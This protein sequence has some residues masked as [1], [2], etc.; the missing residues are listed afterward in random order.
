MHQFLSVQK[1]VHYVNIE[2][3]LNIKVNIKYRPNSEYFGFFGC[4]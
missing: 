3:Q 4:H 2:Q 1:L